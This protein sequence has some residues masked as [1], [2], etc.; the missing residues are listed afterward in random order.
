MKT[1]SSK[2]KVNTDRLPSVFE[3]RLEYGDYS[4]RAAVSRK[5]MKVRHSIKW[6]GVEYQFMGVIL[7]RSRNPQSG[8]YMA[9]VVIDGVTYGYQDGDFK[10]FLKPVSPNM[11]EDGSCWVIDDVD[12][13]KRETGYIMPVYLYYL[14]KQDDDDTVPTSEWV[15]LPREDDV[16][17]TGVKVA[18]ESPSKRPKRQKGS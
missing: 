6:C 1:R 12:K 3:L 7:H 16:V 9:R 13:G 4:I 5:K 18:L 17:I 15:D 8:H 10:E 14:R 11:G 2:F